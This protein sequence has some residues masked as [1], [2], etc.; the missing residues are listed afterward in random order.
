[1]TKIN[2][3]LKRSFTFALIILMTF[4]C[5]LYGPMLYCIFD[6]AISG[7]PMHL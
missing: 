1:M 4:M 2:P 6:C 7:R 5:Y 3:I